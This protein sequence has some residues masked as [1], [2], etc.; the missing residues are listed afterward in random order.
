MYSV[1]GLGVAPTPYYFGEKGILILPYHPHP[2]VKQLK[3]G[4]VLSIVVG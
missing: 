3:V 2:L 1:E 4:Q